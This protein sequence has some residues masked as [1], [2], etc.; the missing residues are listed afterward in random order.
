MTV[1]EFARLTVM[2][3]DNLEFDRGLG[4]RVLQNA[5]N[6]MVMGAVKSV[7]T[8]A[9]LETVDRATSD[10]EMPEMFDYEF[11]D[12]PA[13]GDDSGT[14]KTTRSYTLKPGDAHLYNVGDLHAPRR[15][16]ATKLVRIEG[17]NLDTIKRV[18]HEEVGAQAAK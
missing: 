17:V 11:V 10:I 13:S 14:C 18:Y 1:I 8:T 7:Y 12:A 9:M 5:G 2:A 3:S 16:G 6:V 4:V 15:A